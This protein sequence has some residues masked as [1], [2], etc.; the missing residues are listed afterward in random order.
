MSF[1]KI[2]G[3]RDVYGTE[4]KHWQKI[5]QLIRELCFLY[6]YEEF[7]TPEFESTEVFA[8][9]D[10]SSDMVNKEMYT[11]IDQ[12]NR[13]ITL[14]PEVTAGIVRSVVENKLYANVD[15]PLKYYY[16]ASNFRYENPQKGRLR[17]FHQFGIEA[18][19]A[20]NPLLDLEGITLGVT[21][22]SIL[23]LQQ[24][25][26]LVNTLGDEASRS[27]YREALKEHFASS[28]D[29]MCGD[30]KRRYEQ[31]PLRILDC[32][33]D[34]DH[35]AMKSVPKMSEYL[36]EESKVYFD[37]VIEGLKMLE[38]PYE[39]DEKLVRGLDYYTDTVFEV[40]S[41]HEGMGS[42][43][44]LFAGGRYD[45][46]IEYFGGP[47]ISGIGFGLGLERLLIALE[48]EGVLEVEEEMLDVYVMC[49]DE[50]YQKEAYILLTL[51]R[52]NGYRA[53]M[54]YLGRS[55]KAQFKTVDRKKAQVVAIIGEDEVRLGRVTLKYIP[56]QEQ[57]SVGFD[58]MVAQLDTWANSLQGHEHHHDC[59]CNHDHEDCDGENCHCG[60]HHH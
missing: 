28:I 24:I 36:T 10:D 11:F 6:G 60:H 56:T 14:R 29:T 40:V 43:A 19:G 47:E 21:F 37:Q 17:L 51:A 39:I 57:V 23:G 49:L 2:K 48:E 41:T 27:N 25:K 35:P 59:D 8:R 45:K 50:R 18:L 3:T 42:Q 34:V 38:I 55:M 33:I 32:K 5:E 16:I 30:C 46:L 12:G 44:T 15:L 13:S 1:Q 7:R 20:K 9:Q 53:D 52:A 31:N 54:D 58:E 22:L 26:V 4:I